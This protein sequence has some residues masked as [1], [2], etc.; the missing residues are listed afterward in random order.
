[1]TGI[2]FHFIEKSAGYNKEMFYT[3]LERSNFAVLEG[4]Q[5]KFIPVQGTPEKDRSATN[6]TLIC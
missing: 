3:H 5:V 1:L 2:G 6:V 4:R